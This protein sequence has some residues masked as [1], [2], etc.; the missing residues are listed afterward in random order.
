MKLYCGSV[1]RADFLWIRGWSQVHGTYP[2]M[3]KLL[4]GGTGAWTQV[5]RSE[6]VNVALWP[7][8]FFTTHQW[9]GVCP[10]CYWVKG[11]VKEKQKH[12]CFVT[13]PEAGLLE[14]ARAHRENPHRNKLRPIRSHLTGR[15]KPWTFLL[16][17]GSANHS[18]YQQ[19]KNTIWMQA[20]SPSYMSQTLY[21]T[22]TSKCLCI[23]LEALNVLA[24][25]QSICWTTFYTAVLSVLPLPL[26]SVVCFRMLQ[27]SFSGTVSLR[28]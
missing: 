8:L 22:E 6:W 24:S 14:E 19:K 21:L 25:S 17:D 5:C 23:S 7:S 18:E 10:T 27:V 1:Q 9:A 3:S 4:V 15:S 11:G 26:Y 12:P 16:C 2:K 13:S 20:C 28:T